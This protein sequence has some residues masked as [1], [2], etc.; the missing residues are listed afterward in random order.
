MTKYLAV[1]LMLGACTVATDPVDSYDD[2]DVI[3]RLE[4][5]NM[6]LDEVS[7]HLAEA[8]T[9]L[10]SVQARL[11]AAEAQIES[12]N[13]TL[14]AALSTLEKLD[15]RVGNITDDTIVIAGEPGPA[16]PPGE[17]VQLLPPG[18]SCPGGA[19]V[20]VS[21]STGS[22][23]VCNGY[24]G[25]DGRDGQSIVGPAGP[26]GPAGKDGAN[27]PPLFTNHVTCDA[28]LGSQTWFCGRGT[29]LY[30]SLT[31]HVSYTYGTYGLLFST[32]YF[33][34]FDFNG[35]GYIYDTPGM[36][37]GKDDCLV[38]EY[39]L[40]GASFE[41]ATDPKD[42]RVHLCDGNTVAPFN[43]GNCTNNTKL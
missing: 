32:C 9:E 24:D 31:M 12:D 3:D 25:A 6:G 33:T 16:G 23:A 8:L 27:A 28:T 19:G 29:V 43:A 5:A 41:M 22:Y 39:E 11:D 15:D 21:N 35:G 38:G 17:G 10:Q 26:V 2:S 36:S 7:Q 14:V 18:G 4:S 13:H 30:D 42:I 34:D 1:F 37:V 40:Y 20:M